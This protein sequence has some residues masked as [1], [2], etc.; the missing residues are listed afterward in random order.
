MM[1]KV[2][3]IGLLAIIIHLQGA[4]QADKHGIPPF[5]ITLTDGNLFSSASFVPGKPVILIYFAPSCDHCRV[6][7]KKLADNMNNFKLAQI[8]LV[9]YLPLRDLQNFSNELKLAQFSNLKMG[10]E[11]NAFIVPA[12]YKISIFPFTAVYNRMGRLT[13]IFRKE[14]SMKD[15]QTATGK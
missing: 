8:V 15:L 6:F 14:P 2:L 3:L 7:I 13:A 5:T 10:T 4:A 1:K 9:S 12:F 11:D